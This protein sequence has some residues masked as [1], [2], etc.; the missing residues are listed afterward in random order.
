[1]MHVPHHITVVGDS[2]GDFSRATRHHIDNATSLAYKMNVPDR[3][4]VAGGDRVM[5]DRAIPTEVLTDRFVSGYPAPEL[6]SPPDTLTLDKATFPEISD[7]LPANGVTQPQ[8]ESMSAVSIAVEENPL[9]ELKKM[10]KQLGRLSTRLYQLEDEN[11]RRKTRESF[12]WLSL[13]TTA[14]LLFAILFKRGF[15]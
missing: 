9:R 2:S 6:S 12:L 1:M 15:K 7:E 11:E 3:I 14:G 4:L 10:R 8:D 5:A 13:V